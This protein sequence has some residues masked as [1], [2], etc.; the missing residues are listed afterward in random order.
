MSHERIK[1]L[2]KPPDGCDELCKI[3]KVV[4]YDRVDYATIDLEVFMDQNIPH[5]DH[6]GDSL[7]QANGQQF[8][9]SKNLRNLPVFGGGF[10]SEIRNDVIAN[11]ENR[12]DSDLKI[13]FRAA[14]EKRIFQ[15]GLLG[16]DISDLF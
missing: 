4:F 16:C 13:P 9:G 3:I 1:R 11:I 6:R 8:L 14:R 12:L 15:E 7:G 2:Q 10:Q 5:A